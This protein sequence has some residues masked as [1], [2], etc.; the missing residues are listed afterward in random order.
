MLCGDVH[1]SEPLL[2]AGLDSLGAVQLQQSVRTK[3]GA[4]LPVMVV[5]DYPRVAAL[6]EYVWSVV[7]PDESLDE[8]SAGEGAACAA[9]GARRGCGVL[10]GVG[11]DGASVARS[12]GACE[13]A[14]RL[15]LVR[16]GGRGASSRDGI[17][18]VPEDRWD[19]EG[20]SEVGMRFGGFIRDAFV[21]DGQ[22]AGMGAAESVSYTHLT[23]PTKA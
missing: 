23:L 20:G 18:L 3:L 8:A 19:V 1:P 16:A 10:A 17:C 12:A 9:D 6:Q 2:A 7:C 11:V 21:F 14:S 15:E 4:D 22:L 5:F 13:A